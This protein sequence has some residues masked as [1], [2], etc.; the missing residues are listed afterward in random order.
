MKKLAK[1]LK[2]NLG[3]L[4][5]IELVNTQANLAKLMGVQ[6]STIHNWLHTKIPADKALLLSKKLNI[7]LE[8][9][10]PDFY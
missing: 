6:Q 5:A 3:V 9:L 4:E 2:V 1:K 7:S 10:L 8:K